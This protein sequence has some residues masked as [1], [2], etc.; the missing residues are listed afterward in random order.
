MHVCGGCLISSVHVLT[1][2]QCIYAIQV[3]GGENFEKIS[4]LLGSYIII[5]H[6]IK[7][8]VKNAEYHPAFKPPNALKT[9]AFDIGLILVSLII[10]E[11][12]LMV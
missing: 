7:R 11:K 4:I 6:G 3:S 8:K 9:C 1:A 12:Q 5:G 2:G 10:K